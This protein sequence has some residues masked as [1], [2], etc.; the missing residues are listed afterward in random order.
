MAKYLMFIGPA[1]LLCGAELGGLFFEEAY[2]AAFIQSY[3]GVD[4]A[5]LNPKMVQMIE[6]LVRTGCL[7]GAAASFT[8]IYLFRVMVSIERG[9]VTAFL[10]LMIGGGL[11]LGTTIVALNM[12]EQDTPFTIAACFAPPIVVATLMGLFSNP[13]PES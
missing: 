11:G 5:S 4:P 8:A 13:A 12:L 9:R 1:A 3:L 2:A 7:L 10:G 6:L